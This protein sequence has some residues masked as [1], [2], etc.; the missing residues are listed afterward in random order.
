MVFMKNNKEYN[1]LLKQNAE[2]SSDSVYK[3]EFKYSEPNEV[4][5]VELREKYHLEEAMGV[6]SELEQIIS[7]AKWVKLNTIHDGAHV[8]DDDR[9]AMSIIEKCKNEKKGVN[10]RMIGITMMEVYLSMGFNARY[11][12][13]TPIGFDFKDCHVVNA[14]YSND[15]SKWIFIDASVGVY[16]V[17]E[18]GTPISP[19]D[20]RIKLVDQSKLHIN[21]LDALDTEEIE[22][23]YRMYMTKNMFAISSFRE[24]SPNFESKEID[25][26]QYTLLPKNSIAEERSFEEEWRGGKL[27]NFYLTS[28]TEFW[29]KP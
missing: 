4:G 8:Y 21:K 9:N 14:V 24:A 19:D 20:F 1:H 3:L 16:I 12:T 23:P 11:L 7:L 28:S 29:K 26:V 10:C 27:A 6:G 5:L 2:Y 25:R 15:L 17:D 22:E 18:D 13:C